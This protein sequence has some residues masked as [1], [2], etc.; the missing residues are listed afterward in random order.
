L[1]EDQERFRQL[2]PGSKNFRQEDKMTITE[3]R[4]Q[5]QIADENLRNLRR[6]L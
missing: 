1:E 2:G 6:Y 5:C 3:L 4:E